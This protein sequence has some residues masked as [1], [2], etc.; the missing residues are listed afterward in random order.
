[1]MPAAPSQAR[2]VSHKLL[3]SNQL[4]GVGASHWLARLKQQ[5]KF[6]GDLISRP[7]ES[8]RE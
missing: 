7:Y 5:E 3:N 2:P 4:D 6:A 8:R 1:M